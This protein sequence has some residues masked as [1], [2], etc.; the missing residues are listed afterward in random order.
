MEKEIE[1]SDELEEHLQEMKRLLKKKERSLSKYNRVKRVKDHVRK[2]V[3]KKNFENSCNDSLAVS[4][5]K[6]DA[7]IINASNCHLKS[8]SLKNP[9]T[10]DDSPSLSNGFNKIRSNGKLIAHD[11][12]EVKETSFC[13]NLDS[14]NVP[15]SILKRSLSLESCLNDS[16]NIGTLT[17]DST[18]PI[19]QTKRLSK[20]HLNKKHVKR[21][22]SNNN[23]NNNNNYNYND[24]NICKVTTEQ[25]KRIPCKIVDSKHS[26]TLCCVNS[27]ENLVSLS[28]SQSI[29]PNVEICQKLENENNSEEIERFKD[30]SRKEDNYIS[31]CKP[32]S[33][34]NCILND[35]PNKVIA[36]CIASIPGKSPHII[37]LYSSGF[38]IWALY[39]EETEHGSKFYWQKNVDKDVAF[40]NIKSSFIFGSGSLHCIYFM[41]IKTPSG[42]N[43]PFEVDFVCLSS[44]EQVVIVED[45]LPLRGCAECSFSCC[46]LQDWKFLYSF[47][48][49]KNEFCPNFK[50]SQALYIFSFDF[51]YS[52]KMQKWDL[53]FQIEK[54]HIFEHILLST[55]LLNKCEDMV[56]WCD[57][58]GNFGFVDINYNYMS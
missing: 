18:T 14:I 50:R 15:F 58:S 2:T 39:N 13:S 56:M 31:K 47:H 54:E 44:L 29:K 45:Y 32:V 42:I 55:V 38:S 53:T 22:F 30:T 52:E 49:C 1:I 37:V 16:T 24:Y 28:N 34:D 36:T 33:E 19:I 23:N 6:K 46:D 12:S 9:L 7:S 8:V 25:F 41:L 5:I 48:S 21:L 57:A 3:L 26:H 27:E 51:I 11:C 20:G 35:S 10:A 40:K 4:K 17:S 43:R